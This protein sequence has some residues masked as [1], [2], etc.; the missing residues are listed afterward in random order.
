VKY[1]Y[2][3]CAILIFLTSCMQP[4][5]KKVHPHTSDSSYTITGR[6][7]GVDSG[8]VYLINRQI[9]N[10][11]PDSAQIKNG[12]FGFTGKL[13]APSFCLLGIVN[14]G[15][16]E[17]RLGFFLENGQINITGNKD[18]LDEA[19]V[20]GSATQDEYRQFIASRKPLDE[21]GEK[22]GRLYESIHA[23]NDKRLSD[24]IEKVYGAY[25]GKVKEFVKQYAKSHPSSIIA[26]MQL[27][28]NFSYN[29]D[30][31][32]LE[33]LYNGLDTS[34]MKSFFGNKIKDVLDVAKK[35][36]IGQNA[37]D[38]V[39]NDTGGKPLSL[40]SFKGKYVLL[41]FWA[42]WCGPCR[43]ENPALVKTYREYH[44]RGFDILSV[45]LDDNKEKW[46]AAVSEDH[47][48]WSH[49]SDLKGWQNSA[50]KLYGIQAIPMNFLVDK[51]GRIIA[52]GLRGEDLGK[53]ISEII[54]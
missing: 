22:L 24:S 34:V 47:L 17:F 49:V 53:K 10:D 31:V 30:A 41:D 51:Q 36:A 5:A 46:L 3:L 9:E 4:D 33:K 13:T 38:F 23:K 12:L 7:S 15:Q 1:F 54:K 20:S 43:R 11:S 35:T 44:Q 6:I 26:A 45:S 48:N 28:E 19:L 29:P 14:R 32:E 8:W 18:S 27:Y 52:K 16:K 37:P 50:A 42:S 39:M 2:S 25:D 40:N 21:E